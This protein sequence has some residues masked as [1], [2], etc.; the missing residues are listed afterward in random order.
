MTTTYC[1]H[2]F[3]ESS[4]LEHYTFSYPYGDNAF[5]TRSG[6]EQEKDA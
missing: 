5:A 1:G 6:A 4:L 3:F 2:D